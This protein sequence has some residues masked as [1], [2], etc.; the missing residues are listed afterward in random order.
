MNEEVWHKILPL[1]FGSKV[2]IVKNT[3]NRVEELGRIQLVG[4]IGKVEGYVQDDWKRIMIDNGY[5]PESICKEMMYVLS[6]G[7]KGR[8]A[9]RSSELEVV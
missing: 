2:R 9:Y 7:G 6:F 5:Y 8:Y 1:P 3:I 4:T